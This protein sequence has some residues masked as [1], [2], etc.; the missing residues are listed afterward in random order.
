MD[1]IDYDGGIENRAIDGRGQRAMTRMNRDEHNPLSGPIACSY[2][3]ENRRQ[4][5]GRLS[6]TPLS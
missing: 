3:L 2:Q 5:E 1:A 6:G 4:E